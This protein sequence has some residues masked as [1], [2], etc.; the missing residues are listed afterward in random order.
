VIAVRLILAFCRRKRESLLWLPECGV[1]SAPL[2]NTSDCEIRP[3]SERLGRSMPLRREWSPPA[4]PLISI[5]GD[6]C[7]L[8]GAELPLIL[9]ST[10]AV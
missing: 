9:T 5:R 7:Q 6:V 1:A 10:W 8:E 2:M 4:R 3:S